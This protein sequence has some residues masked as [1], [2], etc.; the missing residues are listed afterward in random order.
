MITKERK[1]I[2][3][4]M[5]FVVSIMGVILSGQ[6]PRY[7][8]LL[9]SMVVIAFL[10]AAMIAAQSLIPSS[11]TSASGCVAAAIISFLVAYLLAAR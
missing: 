9:Y 5:L 4:L 6:W 3:I 10:A 7:T 2:V 8:L 11:K 1:I